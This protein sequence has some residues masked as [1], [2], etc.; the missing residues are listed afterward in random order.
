MADTEA[1]MATRK[2]K[3]AAL[4]EEDK[5]KEEEKNLIKEVRDVLA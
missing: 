5:E 1:P 2:R 4:K 3:R